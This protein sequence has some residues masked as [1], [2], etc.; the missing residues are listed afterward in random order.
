[1]HHTLFDRKHNKR[2]MSNWCNNR[3]S[4]NKTLWKSEYIIK[5]MGKTARFQER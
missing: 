4:M 5:I 1:M 2:E 3:N